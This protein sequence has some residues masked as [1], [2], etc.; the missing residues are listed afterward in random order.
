[1]FRSCIPLPRIQ[2]PG[3][4]IPWLASPLLLPPNLHPSRDAEFPQIKRLPASERS[5]PPMSTAEDMSK[6]CFCRHG[7]PPHLLAWT[8]RKRKILDQ[9]EGVCL[10]LISYLAAPPARFPQGQE[11][12]VN[13]WLPMPTPTPTLALASSCRHANELSLLIQTRTNPCVHW[14]R[15]Q[16]EHCVG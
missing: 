1:M 16:G 10:L 11:N 15:V 13:G 2:S 9:P 3:D 5:K 6:G 4:S 7:H 12:R 8:P 14:G